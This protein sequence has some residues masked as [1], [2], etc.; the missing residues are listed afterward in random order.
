MLKYITQDILSDV[1]AFYPQLGF[2]TSYE[3][4]NNKY[5]QRTNILHH[6]AVGSLARMLAKARSRAPCKA[7]QPSGVLLVLIIK[8]DHFCIVIKFLP[9]LCK[10]RPLW[11]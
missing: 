1:F 3:P 9:Y 7:G 11:G 8:Q 5:L 2:S 6:K 4:T 10:K